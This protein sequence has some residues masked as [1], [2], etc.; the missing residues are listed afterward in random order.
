ML[1]TSQTPNNSVLPDQ[2]APQTAFAQFDTSNSLDSIIT[3]Q[4]ADIIVQLNDIYRETLPLSDIVDRSLQ[5]LMDKHSE[6]KSQALIL[7]LPCTFFSTQT[8]DILPLTAVI[9][10]TMEFPPNLI[11]LADKIRE[12]MTHHGKIS[13]NGVHLRVEK[14]ATDWMLIMGGPGAVWHK[15]VRLMGDMG[16]NQ[17][18]ALYVASGL[19][20]AKDETNWE[21]AQGLLLQHASHILCKERFVPDWELEN[22]HTEQLALLDLLILKSAKTFVG[23]APSTFSHYIKEYRY[24]H[25][26]DRRTSALVNSTKMKS[27]VL[28]DK[29]G[30][31]AP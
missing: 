1:S 18:Q 22:L 23:F 13:Y 21:L 25:G 2:T 15:Y 30:L 3:T 9:A 10:E 16:M 4:D 6:T 27:S 8:E 11:K 28:F 19:A 24:L 5:L 31:I 26:L 7:D 14:D 29:S 17:S 20:S 12:V